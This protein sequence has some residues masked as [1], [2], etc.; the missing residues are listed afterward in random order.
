MLILFLANAIVKASRIKLVWRRN[1]THPKGRRAL[2][3]GR[4]WN[5]GAQIR[6]LYAAFA[7]TL[8]D[9]RCNLPVNV[10]I[11]GSVTVIE[12]KISAYK[13]W[14]LQHAYI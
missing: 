4:V 5:E 1:D 6:S 9:H 10:A 7:R 11:V 2:C 3:G 8:H 12:N 13:Y 14:L